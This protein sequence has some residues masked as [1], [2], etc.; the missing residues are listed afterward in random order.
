MHQKNR[1]IFLALIYFEH[2]EQWNIINITI[3]HASFYNFKQRTQCAYPYI[4]QSASFILFAT[5]LTPSSSTYMYPWTAAILM[6][7]TLISISWKWIKRLLS[8]F[9]RIKTDIQPEISNTNFQKIILTSIFNFFSFWRGP[10]FLNHPVWQRRLCF[11]FSWLNF[12]S[13]VSL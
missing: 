10:F 4:D 13:I 11:F 1:T 3:T 2:H 5:I 8:G 7:Y 12:Y 9:Y 6:V